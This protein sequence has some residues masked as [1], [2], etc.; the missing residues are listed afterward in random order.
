[1]QAERGRSS[2]RARVRFRKQPVRSGQAIGIDE[3]ALHFVPVDSCAICIAIASM[4]PPPSLSQKPHE[5][6][7][8]ANEAF[9]LLCRTGDA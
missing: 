2:Q 8:K 7:G 3:N 4:Q 9:C 6:T 1:M 5:S